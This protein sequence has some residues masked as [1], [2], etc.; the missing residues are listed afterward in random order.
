MTP[1]KVKERGYVRRPSLRRDDVA[2]P[3]RAYTNNLLT[4]AL[5]VNTCTPGS[6]RPNPSNQARVPS[7][8]HDPSP[9]PMGTGFPR[10]D[11]IWGCP[12]Y[13]LRIACRVMPVMSGWPKGDIPKP[14]TWGRTRT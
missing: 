1:T 8:K 2:R 13:F 11:G 7:E 6:H 10:Y 4:A 5:R 12:G 9:A 3:L 14:P